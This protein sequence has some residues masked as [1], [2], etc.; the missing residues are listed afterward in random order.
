MTLE[1]WKEAMEE[2]LAGQFEIVSIGIM[3]KVLVIRHREWTEE[4]G[5]QCCPLIAFAFPDP[6]GS[7]GV[8]DGS[9]ACAEFVG[10]GIGLDPDDVAVVMDAADDRACLSGRK[11]EE[12]REWMEEV[13]VHGEDVDA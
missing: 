6:D 3:A 5:N 11:G 2:R 13:L 8:Y 10:I 1:E 9:N 7:K 12:L 4:D